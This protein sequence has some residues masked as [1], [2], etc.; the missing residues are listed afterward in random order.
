MVSPAFLTKNFR[1]AVVIIAIL[2][3]LI[4]PTPDPLNMGLVMSP[5][6]LLY[7]LGILLARFMY[8]PRQ[9]YASTE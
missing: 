7:G 1:F 3:A 2:S 4:T 6:L 5:L 8:R 9:S